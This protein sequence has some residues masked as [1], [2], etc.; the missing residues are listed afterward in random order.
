MNTIT[1]IIISLFSMSMV[2]LAGWFVW[3]IRGNVQQAGQYREKL[4]EQ[5][6]N[7]RLGHM[8]RS[9]GID[10]TRYTHQVPSV[11]IA[12]HISNCQQCVR[13]TECDQI[14]ENQ[15][16]TTEHMDFCPNLDALAGI[17]RDLDG[18]VDRQLPGERPAATTA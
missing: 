17:K 4:G 2:G 7:E 5:V 18:M 11:D 1:G 14:L 12:G 16:L 15:P 3:A 13:T 9:L 6:G 8:L 10:N